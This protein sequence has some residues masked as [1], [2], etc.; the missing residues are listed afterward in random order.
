MS[1]RSANINRRGLSLQEIV[2][3]RSFRH[4][5]TFLRR[6]VNRKSLGKSVVSAYR[7]VSAPYN[8]LLWTQSSLI[9]NCFRLHNNILKVMI[10]KWSP[11]AFWMNSGV[12]EL[13]AWVG[14]ISYSR[15]ASCVL[16]F[17][18]LQVRLYRNT[19]LPGGTA[20]Q[21]WRRFKLHYMTRMAN[22]TVHLSHNNHRSFRLIWLSQNCNT[23]VVSPIVLRL[24]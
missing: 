17:S 16:P 24:L 7:V 13:N 14:C 23:I 5:F 3:D 19:L 20:L 9:Y 15:R 1:S 4:G 12:N 21:H 6:R 22:V 11:G 2:V 18:S 10:L 8:D